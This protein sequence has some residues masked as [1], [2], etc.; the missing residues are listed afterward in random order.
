MTQLDDMVLACQPFYGI[1]RAEATEG[2]SWDFE[3]VFTDDTGP[4]VWT[5][6][7]FAAAVLS[8]IDGSTVVPLTV[9]GDA[10]GLVKLLA[11]PTDTAGDAGTGSS[12]VEYPWYCTVTTPTSRKFA[13]WTQEKSRVVVRQGP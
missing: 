13:L 5:G 12:P 10:S 11:A 2:M 6:C 1:F 3:Y 9:T 8:A 7:T 4:I